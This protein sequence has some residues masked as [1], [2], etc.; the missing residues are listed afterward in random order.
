MKYL[1]K[2]KTIFPITKESY[3]EIIPIIFFIMILGIILKLPL[4][5]I[6]SFI[7]S[8]ILLIIGKS[9]F[10]FGAK[11]AVELLGKKIGINLIKSNKTI[12]IILSVFLIG[13]TIT[14]SEP[15]L[16]TLSTQLPS[17][18]KAVLIISVSISVGI[19]LVIG[20][21]KNIY[22]LNLNTLLLIGYAIIFALLIFTPSQYIPISFDAGGATTGPVSVPFIVALGLGLNSLR[23]D[24]NAKKD[25][26]GSLALC[27]IGPIIIVLILG[28]FYS[29]ESHY[30]IA[31]INLNSGLYTL[32]FKN[33][34]E[35]FKEV[36]ITTIP[37]IALFLVYKKIFKCFSK[38]D[39][40]KIILGLFLVIVGFSIFL[41]GTNIGFMPMG[42]LL[43]TTITSKD[44][45][46]I[47]IPIGMI[48]GY[49]IVKAEPAVNLLNEQIDTIT[50]GSIK[51]K[52][53]SLCLSLAVS[54]AVAISF[55][56]AFTGLNIAY[57]LIPCYILTLILTF[58][59]NRLFTGISFD[60]G[61]AVSGPLTVSFL[62]PMAIGITYSQGG[63]IITDAF[64]L[65]ALVNLFPI[66]TIQIFGLIY[67]Y[68][69][70]IL[71]TYDNYSDEI[72]S[73]NW[74]K[75]LW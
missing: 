19:F 23:V 43:G 12:L 71:K 65:I 46:Y 34:L 4:I 37:L 48:L 26:F 68:K 47:I 21:I 52:N 54:L 41:V 39:T 6:Y 59:V 25:G 9:I 13:F 61:G 67:K 27:S 70:R 17:I 74:R 16:L 22:R 32:Y 42:N 31:N 45:K 8:G 15:D 20:I 63:N 57:I 40:T 30:E 69:S 72:I 33:F 28:L 36:L 58:F 2:I 5:N 51:K 7:L 14:L 24:K 38:K 50:S 60:A 53:V 73:Y 1:E 64:G 75:Y 18:P 66:V 49:L 3:Y 11:L 44:Y 56:R 10:T 55:Y 35:S 62:L 29:L